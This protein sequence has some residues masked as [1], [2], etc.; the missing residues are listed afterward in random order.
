MKYTWFLFLGKHRRYWRNPC[1]TWRRFDVECSRFR[2]KILMV[3]RKHFWGKQNVDFTNKFSKTIVFFESW[4]EDSSWV[5]FYFSPFCIWLTRSTCMATP[6]WNVGC[7]I[8]PHMASISHWLPRS[9]YMAA[10][11]THIWLP[12]PPNI[13]LLIIVPFSVN[14]ISSGILNLSAEGKDTYNCALLL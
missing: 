10:L 14:D 6:F 12:F 3:Y 7:S 5:L 9:A 13:A 8:S 11:S 4:M 1:K 2:K